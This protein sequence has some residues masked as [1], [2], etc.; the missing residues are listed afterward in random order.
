MWANQRVFERLRLGR[1]GVPPKLPNEGSR[2]AGAADELVP[3]EVRQT[4]IIAF[5]QV[6]KAIDRV[7]RP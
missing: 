7:L 6:S 1:R 2:A 4:F 3:S 5:A